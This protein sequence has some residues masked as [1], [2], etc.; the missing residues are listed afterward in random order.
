MERRLWGITADIKVAWKELDRFGVDIIDAGCEYAKAKRGLVECFIAPTYGSTRFKFSFL[1]FVNMCKTA[2]MR[3]SIDRIY[4]R[5]DDYVVLHWEMI[6]AKGE[7]PLEVEQLMDY[8]VDSFYERFEL[9]KF[10][11]LYV[12]GVKRQLRDEMFEYFLNLTTTKAIASNS[13]LVVPRIKTEA[14]DY[15]PRLSPL[16]NLN[17]ALVAR[18]TQ[19]FQGYEL[20]TSSQKAYQGRL[21]ESRERKSEIWRYMADKFAKP[22]DEGK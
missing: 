3:D 21:D 14:F 19:V 11:G 15:N 7:D 17:L 6:R 9:E 4:Q 18:E 8:L 12:R 1:D 13:K 10:L 22:E 5:E 2:H 20:M 16:E